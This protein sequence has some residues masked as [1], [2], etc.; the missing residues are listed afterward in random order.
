MKKFFGFIKKHKKLV[1][2][3]AIVAA[4]AALIIYIVNIVGQAQNL[5]ANTTNSAST[6]KIEVRDIVNSVTATGKIVAAEQRTI[7]TTVTGVDV[8][9]LNV[10]VGDKVNAGDIICLLDGEELETQLADAQKS[11]NAD[12]GRSSID[13]E[14]SNRNL[15]DAIVSR[16]ID[17]KRSEEDKNAAYN[18]YTSAADECAEAENDYN[19]AKN[20]T[21]SAKN[22]M[23]DAQVALDNINKAGAGAP[24]A[25]ALATAK[26]EV[27]AAA[28]AY[29]STV[30]SITTFLGTLPSAEVNA[31][32][33]T[34]F[35]SADAEVTDFSNDYSLAVSK[36]ANVVATDVYTGADSA[37]RAEVEARLSELTVKATAFE[38]AVAQYNSVASAPAQMNETQKAAA[39]AAYA[40]AQAEYEAA[41][42]KEE[43]AKSIYEAKIKT[44]ES[45]LDTYNR[46]LRSIE[47]LKR[48]DDMSVASR[49]DSLKNS[50]ISA[51]TATIGDDRTI[52]QIEDQLHSCVVTATIGG[53]V[54]AV[55][56]I[57]GDTY[58]GGAIVT[59]EDTANYEVSAQIDE[60]DIPKVEIGQSVVV[61]TNGTGS[62]EFEGTV[63]SIAPHATAEVGTSGVKYEVRITI[64]NPDE[65]IKLDMTAKIEIVKDKKEAALTVPAEAIQVDEED[66]REFVEIL[67][68]GRPIDSS[69]MLTDPTSVSVEDQE[70]LKNG[71]VN[72]ESHRVYITRGIEGDYYIEIIGEGLE[73]GMEV[74]VPNGGAYA[75]I[76]AYLEEAGATG[77]F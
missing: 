15:N 13:V 32:V 31:G 19:N 57:K 68:S 61:K 14:A 71:D 67:D 47:D 6:E 26:G 38:Q 22:A 59:I 35:D 72:Y 46:T 39:E 63:K 24:D 52:R 43:S 49:A 55:N 42:A 76:N 51:G 64:N 17:A 54:T 2:L 58:M 45:Q 30:S 25:T 41:K 48:N 12:A 74:V 16:D 77:G 65:D 1:I 9:E 53:T 60:F 56:V 11:K 28:G 33:I 7:S 10:A 37:N 34:S 23:Y 40:K 29:D 75:D 3:L 5:L 27:V 69:K 21:S 70:K 44:V 73:E 36:N 66:G 8:K 62:K 50:R 20:A 18:Q 4:I